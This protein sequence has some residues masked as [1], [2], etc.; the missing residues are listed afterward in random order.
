MHTLP[1]VPTLHPFITPS[2]RGLGS[3]RARA[4]SAEWG[5]LTPHVALLCHSGYDLVAGS[6]L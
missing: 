4:V 2:G 1:S 3:R 5:D 6:S